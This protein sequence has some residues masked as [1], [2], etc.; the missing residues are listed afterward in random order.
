MFTVFVFEL[1]HTNKI[2]SIE[3]RL[4]IKNSG[5]P[6]SCLSQL[7]LKGTLIFDLPKVQT[8]ITILL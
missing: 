3:N 2:D 8:G 6:G 4:C 1:H 7:F 5:F